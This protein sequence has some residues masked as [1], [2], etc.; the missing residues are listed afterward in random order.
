MKSESSLVP[1]IKAYRLV[2]RSEPDFSHFALRHHVNYGA[3]AII[4]DRVS[5]IFTFFF[6]LLYISTTTIT[7]LLF[8]PEILLTVGIPGFIIFLCLG[9]Y[10]YN[11]HRTLRSEILSVLLCVAL[12]AGIWSSIIFLSEAFNSNSFFWIY[13]TVGISITIAWRLLA[14]KITDLLFAMRLLRPRRLLLLGVSNLGTTVLRSIRHQTS[15]WTEIV[16]YVSVK[17][18]ERGYDDL[19]MLSTLSDNLYPLLIEH[20][21]DDIVVTLPEHQLALQEDIAHKLIDMPISVLVPRRKSQA[22]YPENRDIT[23]ATF[24]E[25]HQSQASLSYMQLVMKRMFDIFSALVGLLLV[26]PLFI[27]LAI[28]IKL[29]SKGSVFFKQERVGSSGHIFKILKFRSMCDKAEALVDKVKTVDEHG[30]TIYKKP[31]D[32]RVT[33]VGKMIR[34]T[35]LDE[36]PQLINVLLGDMSIVGPR[37]EVVRIV[38]DE[39]EDWQ[40]RR[41]A[42]PQGIT[43][44]WQ[45]NGRSESPCYLST[46]LDIYYIENY[47]FALDIKII[48]MTFPALLKGKGAF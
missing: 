39:Y 8:H 40:Y 29:D 27:V 32:W 35:S 11:P 48:M 33:R 38:Q 10:N 26:L 9:V 23:L 3:I 7:N 41:F 22:A 21:I 47:S 14:Y 16:G 2:D 17:D 34:R 13:Y 31:N 18:G 37:P 5:S 30:K 6:A 20:K 15:S 43:G 42:V 12:E 44:W 25:L 1:E 28:A 45:V 24:R 4:L 46:D 19:P 36:L